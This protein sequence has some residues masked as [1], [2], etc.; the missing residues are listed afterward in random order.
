M[1]PHVELDRSDYHLRLMIERMQRAGRS[2]AVID[3][4]VR[5]ASG[6]HAT[7]QRAAP[8]ARRWGKPRQLDPDRRAAPTAFSNSTTEAPKPDGSASCPTR[9]APR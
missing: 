4:A 9:R 7:D 2:E 6:I 1:R 3:T 8:A 5:V